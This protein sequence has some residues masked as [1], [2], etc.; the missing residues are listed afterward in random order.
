M[1]ERTDTEKI[2]GAAIRWVRLR[3][4]GLALAVQRGDCFCE[5]E[6]L[7][8]NAPDRKPLP[9]WK[10]FDEDGERLDD[11]CDT[12]I[13]RQAFHDELYPIAVARGAALRVLIRYARAAIDAKERG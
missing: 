9:C 11:W 4:E 2:A 5:R 1:A 8:W 12:C 7:A 10:T 3:R 13:K 6:L